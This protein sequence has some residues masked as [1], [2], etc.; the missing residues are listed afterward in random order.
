MRVKCLAAFR[1]R[2]NKKLGTWVVNQFISERSHELA[3]DY[4][5]KFLLSH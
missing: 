3:M 1:V 2:N 4:E 5:V